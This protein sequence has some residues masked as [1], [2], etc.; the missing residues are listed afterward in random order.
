M[1]LFEYRCED[2]GHVTEFLEKAG[3]T[4]E[5]TCEKCGSTRM[6]KLLSLC[7]VSVQQSPECGSACQFNKE[8]GRCDSGACGMF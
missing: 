6:M 3:N 7:S 2:C 8:T 4:D 1:P 5:H